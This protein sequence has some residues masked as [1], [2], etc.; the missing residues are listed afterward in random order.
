MRIPENSKKSER[1]RVNP[2]ESKNNCKESEIIREEYERILE[3]PVKFLEDRKEFRRILE[4]E[5]IHK[6]SK[7]LPD[8]RE[9]EEY[10]TTLENLEEYRRIRLNS[11]KI[12]ANLEEFGRIRKHPE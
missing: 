2:R 7:K 1:I 9:S 6:G 4:S 3:N 8:L 5:R 12:E 11:E 10:E